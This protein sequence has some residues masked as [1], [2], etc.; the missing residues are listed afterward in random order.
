MYGGHSKFGKY[1]VNRVSKIIWGHKNLTSHISVL[2]ILV[3][4]PQNTMINEF[5]TK[6]DNVCYMAESNHMVLQGD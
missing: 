3:H 5:S 1:Y 4:F 2:N 6:D